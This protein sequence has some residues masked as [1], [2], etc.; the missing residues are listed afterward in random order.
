MP[1]AGFKPTI[2]GS[3]LPQTNALHPA[4]IYKLLTEKSNG[5]DCFTDLGLKD[6]TI[7]N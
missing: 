3:E 1:S 2:P 4:A 6:S 7:L 5:T